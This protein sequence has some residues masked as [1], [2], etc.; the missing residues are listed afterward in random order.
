[1]CARDDC[2]LGATEAARAARREAAGGAPA[3]YSDR[4]HSAAPG[5]SLGSAAASLGMRPGGGGGD[6]SGGLRVS[7]GSMHSSGGESSAYPSPLP[8]PTAP[9]AR[10]IRR[11]R[12]DDDDDGDDGVP[13]GG[14][15]TSHSLSLL[16]GTMDSVDSMGCSG[17]SEMYPGGARELP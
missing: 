15:V 12:D 8:P 14:V 2:T 17:G 1:M 4:P 10:W 16:R 9:E 5:G 7:C 3:G 13:P 6:I 11:H